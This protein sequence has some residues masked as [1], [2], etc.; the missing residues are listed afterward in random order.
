MKCFVCVFVVGI[1]L[2]LFPEDGLC[3]YKQEE[4]TT[5]EFF[6]K[7]I[8]TIITAS[9]REQRIQDSPSSI[10]VI[11]EEDIKESG[12]LSIPDILRYIPGLDVMEITSS[13]WEVNARGLNQIRSNKMLVLID[14]RSVYFDYFGGVIWQG[15]PITLQDIKRIEVVRS[16]ISALYGANALSGIINIITKSPRE[17]SGTFVTLNKGN[18]KNISSSIIH[19]GTNGNLGY[20]LSGTIRDINSWR[21]NNINS[22]ERK[23]GN[24]KANYFING[25]SSLAFDAG[26]ETGSI[27]QI[28]LSSILKFDGNTNYIKANYNYS[29]FNMQFFWNHGDINSPSFVG[30]GEKA[31]SKYNTFDWELTHTLFLGTKNTLSFGSSIRLNRIKSTIINKNHNQNLIAGFMQNEFKPNNKFIALLGLRVDN[32]PLVDIN[33]SPRASIVFEPAE[34]HIF[35]FTASKAF[36]NPT[37]SDSYLQVALAPVPLPSP[38]LP[39]GSN[40]LLIVKGNEELE[41]ENIETYEFGYQTFYKSNVK[42]KIDLFHNKVDNFIGTGDFIPTSFFLDPGTGAPIINPLTGLPIPQAMTQSF[43]NL[44]YAEMYGGEFEFDWLVNRWLRFRGNYSY[45]EGNN[46]YTLNHY[47]MPPKNKI[48]LITDYS[49][50]NGLSFSIM[51]RYIDET[52]WDIDTNNDSI[53]EK[54][55]TPSFISVDTRLSYRIKE[56]KFYSDFIMHNIFNE[57]HKEYPIAESVG[58]RISIRLNYRY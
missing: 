10:S 7:N 58:R 50:D 47:S 8:E 35:R 43:V 15:L 39:E 48:N 55:I 4:K 52:K 24:L 12:A 21:D 42:F 32:H 36:R 16:P 30:Y 45:T 1:M 17:S 19:G 13:H 49:F 22:E 14:G 26:Y 20:K 44:G 6:F 37:F 5:E 9:K 11:T 33:Y 51:G 29:N 56:S 57:I 53:P 27:E 18:L 41:P 28:I 25:K 31:N 2:A 54:H 38:P 40:M 3:R 34:N 23:I 46:R